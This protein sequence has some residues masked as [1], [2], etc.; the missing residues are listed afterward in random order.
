MSI[1][2]KY[3]STVQ[4]LREK[5]PEYFFESEFDSKN[6]CTWTLRC[7]KGRNFDKECLVHEIKDRNPIMKERYKI[8][9]MEKFIMQTQNN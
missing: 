5:Y 2:R 9:L 4:Q 6:R 1:I 3:C 7:Y 8:R